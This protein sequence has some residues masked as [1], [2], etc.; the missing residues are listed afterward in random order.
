MSVAVGILFNPHKPAI[1]KYLDIL[2]ERLARKGLKTPF[3]L[4]TE[5][6]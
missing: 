1:E 2:I 4:S 6:P 5:G 3:A